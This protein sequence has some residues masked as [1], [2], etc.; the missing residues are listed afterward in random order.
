MDI[1]I[2]GYIA[3]VC[4]SL[5]FLP[6]ALKVI[7]SKNTDALSL[8]MYSVF[9]FGVIMWLVYALLLGDMPMI[10]A[11]TVT[12]TLALIIFS[13]KLKHTLQ[14]MSRQANNTH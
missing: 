13:M 9:T 14:K 11:N 1:Q 4:T 3:A 8:S 12:L 6:Q 7:K 10:L 2:F 5:S